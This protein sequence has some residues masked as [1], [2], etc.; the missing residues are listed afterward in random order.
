MAL[1]TD[2]SHRQADIHPTFHRLFGNTIDID[3]PIQCICWLLDKMVGVTFGRQ[4]ITK[5]E[6]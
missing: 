5:E 2:K 6:I 4:R 1:P 3:S